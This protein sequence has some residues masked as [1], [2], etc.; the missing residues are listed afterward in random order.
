MKLIAVTEANPSGF[1]R[2]GNAVSSTSF[3]SILEKKNS[4]CYLNRDLI[5]SIREKLTRII[6]QLL[7]IKSSLRF[8]VSVI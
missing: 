8:S 5:A 6:L 4:L 7:A 2:S 1:R 3:Q